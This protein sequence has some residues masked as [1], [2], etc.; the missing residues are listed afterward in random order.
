MVA[1]WMHELA[2][3]RMRIRLARTAACSALLVCLVPRASAQGAVLRLT[4]GAGA[5]GSAVA[6]DLMLTA[7]EQPPPA[8]LQW[9]LGYSQGA[10][11]GVAV[12]GGPAARDAGK[13]VSC[14]SSAETL[15]CVL[16]G[17]NATP[18]ANGVAA[19][20]I[21]TI[22]PNAGAGTVPITV[23]GAAAASPAAAPISTSAEG[24]WVTIGQASPLVTVDTNP[25]GLEISVDGSSYTAP[26][27]FPSAYGATHVIGAPSPQG[28]SGTRHVFSHWTDGGAQTHIVITSQAAARH[29]ANFQTLYQLSLTAAPPGAGSITASPAPPDGYYP[30]DSLVQLAAVA[31]PG[32]EFA[33]WSG[34]LAA[35]APLALLQMNAPKAVSALFVPTSSCQYSLSR[36]SVSSPAEG[37][38]GRLEV[39]AGA[40]CPWTAAAQDD[41]I[42]VTSGRS[43]A[44][45]GT[46]R[47]EVAAN[48][49]AGG[50]LRH[51]SLAAG[52]RTAAVAQMSAGCSV[53][54][55]PSSAVFEAAGG[56]V[57]IAAS[58][59]AGCE[60]MLAAAPAWLSVTPPGGTGNGTALL[61][62][63]P[64]P[65]L[66]PRTANLSA[67]GAVIPVMQSGGLRQVFSD[68]PVSHPYRNHILLLRL[69]GVTSGC[70]S[71][72]F[73]PEDP[74]TRGQ[75]AVFVS[76]AIEGGDTFHY[77]PEPYFSDVPPQHPYFRYIQRMR[78][79]GV[80]TGCTATQY[81]PDAPVTRGQMAVFLIRARLGDPPGRTF[82]YPGQRYFVDVAPS[83]E[84]FPFIQKLRQLGITTGCSQTE[85]CPGGTVTRG[86]MAV[87]LIRAFF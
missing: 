53:G 54:L 57:S 83:H 3:R 62:A 28:F 10:L 4:S 73:C 23:S 64:N 26:R 77:T 35:D 51:G 69:H 85:Y 78:D 72:G 46:V 80:T 15:S 82:P 42:T 40:G 81:C 86:Q 70:T 68:V 7:A 65:G 27:V 79:L 55:G 87:F 20:V 75:M 71:S 6:L 61:Q 60:W 38:T 36:P 2:W 29:T 25:P 67:G 63:A 59:P 34:G 58:A 45:G 50:R 41:W 37:D 11:A 49:A 74:V 66:N 44:G 1:P 47:F 14:R 39:S 8:A 76:R 19:R 18:M 84:Y 17:L 56:A 52:G 12:E 5:P 31:A 21:V 48:A 43:G 24:G 9:T 32:Y 33:G 22:S 16:Y 13:A 30:G